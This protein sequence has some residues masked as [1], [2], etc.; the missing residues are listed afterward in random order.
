MD[1]DMTARD[2]A[3]ELLTTQLIRSI[4]GLPNKGTQ[5]TGFLPTYGTFRL[6]MNQRLAIRTRCGCCM[7][8]TC[9]ATLPLVARMFLL[10]Q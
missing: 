7:T 4:W 1:L 3:L 2:Y 6:D 9:S 8:A 10:G 5:I